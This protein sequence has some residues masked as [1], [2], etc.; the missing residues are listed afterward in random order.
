MRPERGALSP[1]YLRAGRGNRRR[2]RATASEER[3]LDQLKAQASVAT[4]P[5]GILHP[6]KAKLVRVEF[7]GEIRQVK[8]AG[9]GPGYEV[10]MTFDY[11]LG[12]DDPRTTSKLCR[13]NLADSS[14]D[15][16]PLK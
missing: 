16:Q 12:H 11:K 1:R 8:L 13:M 4:P 5:P 7:L 3:V 10:G 2:C 6:Q 15:W 9:G 14:V